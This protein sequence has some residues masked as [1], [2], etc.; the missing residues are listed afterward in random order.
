MDK[1]K[2]DK[3]EVEI[4]K[5]EMEILVDK[6][7]YLEDEICIIKDQILGIKTELSTHYHKLLKEGIDLRAEGLI[8]IIKEIFQLKEKVLLSFLPNYLDEKAIVCLFS[9]SQLV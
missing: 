4:L 9:V 1:S 6:R 5:S 2:R 8:W 3:K 7:L